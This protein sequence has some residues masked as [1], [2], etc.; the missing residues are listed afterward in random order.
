[1][2]DGITVAP[3]VPDA[4]RICLTCRWWRRDDMPGQT[5]AV[6]VWGNCG[7]GFEGNVL[8]AGRSTTDMMLCSGHDWREDLIVK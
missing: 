7:I 4:P 5:R 8:V 3:G 1:M 6:S 2:S